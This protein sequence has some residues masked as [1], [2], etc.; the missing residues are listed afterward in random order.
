MG[1]YKHICENCGKDFNSDFESTRFCSRECYKDHRNKN[2]KLKVIMCPICHTEFK[3]KHK[4]QIFCSVACRAKSTEKKVECVCDYCGKTFWRKPS[5][6]DNNKRH[7]CSD[8]CKRK[9]MYWSDYDTDILRDNFGKLTYKEMTHLFSPPK[10][11][12]EIKRRAIYIGLTESP[13]W[14]QEE[15]DILIDSYSNLPIQEVLELLPNRSLMSI[16]GQAKVQNLK[17]FYYLSRRYSEEDEVYLRENYLSK[18][19]KELADKLN[20]VPSAI[21]QH[22]CVMGLYRP[23]ER[24]KNYSKLSDYIRGQ[25]HAWKV[26]IREESNYRCALTGQKSNIIIHHI[27]GFNLLLSESIENLNFPIYEEMSQYT[28]DQLDNLMEEFLSLQEY[29]GQY[30]CIAEDVHIHFHSIYG[31]GSNT[32]EQWN[33]FVNTYYKK[34][35]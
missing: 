12:D 1:K 27:R 10:T 4:E 2:G 35:N 22:L 31:C 6:V 23:Y 19:N 16:R 14:S 9:G 33:E 13:F 15:I 11:V 21:A 18:N 25:L 3:Q 7:Y 34:I 28:Q 26:K 17:S 5:E 8:E 30:I 29:Y 24:E 32:E 20:R